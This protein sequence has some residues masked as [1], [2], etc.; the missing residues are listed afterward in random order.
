MQFATYI[1]GLANACSEGY[2]SC[3]VAQL[4]SSNGD[5]IFLSG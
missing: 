2:V 3:P 5:W 4:L 1:S